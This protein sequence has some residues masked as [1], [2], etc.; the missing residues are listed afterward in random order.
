MVYLFKKFCL[1]LMLVL[2]FLIGIYA[3]SRYAYFP[4]VMRSLLKDL[5]FIFLW[6]EYSKLAF[7]LLVA[8][9]P[10]FYLFFSLRG[11]SIR[12]GY[13][14]KGKEGNSVI[15]KGAI[16][17]SL[18]SAVRTIPSV[19][20]VRPVIRSERGGLCITLQTI[21]KLEQ[22]VPN[23]CERIRSRAR[24]TLIDVLGIDRITRIDVQIAE[25]KLLHPP[26]AERI[27]KSPREPEKKSAAGMVS[28]KP[29]AP[30]SRSEPPSSSEDDS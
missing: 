16:V 30:N 1:V 27:P 6:S 3:L 10:L 8:L 9:L 17:K 22:F 15:S 24:S 18:I 5:Y 26:I 21:I 25:V 12:E 7:W 11:Y 28:L 13:L 2:L 20:K 19:I 4:S 23:I 14:I 29:A